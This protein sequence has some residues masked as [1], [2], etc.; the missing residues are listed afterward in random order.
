[1][2]AQKYADKY[3][4]KAISM[5][6][7]SIPANNSQQHL[8]NDDG[9]DSVPSL[10]NP[11]QSAEGVRP[12][13]SVRSWITI[14]VLCYV[15]LIN[16]M[17]RFTI[18]GILKEVQNE[19]NIGDSYGGLL[20]TVFVISYMI[21]APLFGY[22]GDRYSRRWLMAFGVAL[23]TLMTLIGSFMQDYRLFLLFRALVGIGEASYST[24]SPTIISDLFLSDLR[25][26]MLAIFYFAIP[27]GS[28]LGY[29][30]GASGY[31]L[32]GNWRFGLRFTPCLGLIAVLLIIF[33]MSD[34]PRGEI[35]GRGSL[36][37]GNYYKDV[38]SLLKNK[39]F[40][41]STLGFTCVAFVTGA[42]AWWAPK[43][44]AL[45]Q[46]IISRSQ[47]DNTTE[48]STIFGLTAM[49][50]GAVGVPLG[51]ILANKGR[52]YIGVKAD[53]LVCSVSLVLSLSFLIPSIII[54]PDDLQCYIL[55]F[56]AQ[57]FINFNWAI[58][59]DITLYV[60]LPTRRSSAEA[61]Q[62]LISHA[63]GDAGSPY[64]VG[65]ISDALKQTT[66]TENMV[67]AEDNK[68]E[69]DFRTLQYALFTTCFI[70]IIGAIC[71]LITSFYI[72]EDKEMAIIESEGTLEKGDQPTNHMYADDPR[73]NGSEANLTIPS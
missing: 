30:T 65:V 61:F 57:V 4:L 1:M 52:K 41:L 10:L 48:V 47:V 21:F 37:A 14:G 17:D 16:Y 39:S 19:F 49:I 13:V 18:A 43:F 59:A 71:F 2:P 35:E 44:I 9:V 67:Q 27:V 8:M 26:K 62:I 15:N 46:K 20:Q 45:G 56:L 50:A 5:E 24:I 55:I 22:L 63:L 68:T 34:P 31:S 29:I 53:A 38:K 36:Q 70:E 7:V 64:L 33:V 66:E 58:V 12:P 60:V 54:T 6:T 73:L 28:G 3:S 72:I 23:W 11:S 40:M 42:L 51:T 32:F 25:S 69:V